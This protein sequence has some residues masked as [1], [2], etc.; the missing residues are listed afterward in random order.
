M[1]SQQNLVAHLCDIEVAEALLNLARN[2]LA[3]GV[4]VSQVTSSAVTPSVQL[5]ILCDGCGATICIHTHSSVQQQ[6]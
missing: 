1:K 4:A 2:E 5:P 3:Q 6:V